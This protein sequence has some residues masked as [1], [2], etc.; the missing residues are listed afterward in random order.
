M[1]K[2]IILKAG[3]KLDSLVS[4]AGDFEDWILDKMPAL[5]ASAKV[6]NIQEQI[7]F[8]PYP[9]ICGIVITGSSAM[10]TDQQEW[11]I[12]SSKWLAGAVSASIP[13][14]GICFGHQL[15]AYCLGGKVDYNPMGVEV[16]TV[17]IGLLDAADS[18]PLFQGLEPPLLA[19]ASHRQCVLET[20]PGSV[21]LASTSLDKNHAFRYGGQAWGVQFHPEFSLEVVNAYIDYY[22]A[23]L[24]DNKTNFDELRDTSGETTLGTSIFNHFLDRILSVSCR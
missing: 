1:R 23:H 9:D 5:K 19:Q 20:P 22:A 21:C 8:P 4:V 24:D 7:E 11:M 2:L 13:V 17:R 10:V 15:L 16:G 12:R 6:L 3:S 18:D 14:L